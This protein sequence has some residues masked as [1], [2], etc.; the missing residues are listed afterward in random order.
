MNGRKSLTNAEFIDRR[1]PEST[2]ET[3]TLTSFV[4]IR[5]NYFQYKAKKV[6]VIVQR[7]G[8]SARDALD[9]VGL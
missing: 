4:D 2:N 3:L 8:C 9:W 6:L 5:N 1:V 7:R